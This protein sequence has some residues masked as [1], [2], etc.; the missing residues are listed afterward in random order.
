[1]VVFLDIIADLSSVNSE[2]PAPIN[3]YQIRYSLI[4]ICLSLNGP[5][6]V[7]RAIPGHLYNPTAWGIY[8]VLLSSISQLDNLDGNT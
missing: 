1:M 6:E 5:H 2:T 7:H 3:V 4:Y 8:Y